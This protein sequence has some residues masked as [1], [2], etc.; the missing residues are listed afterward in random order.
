M[1]ADLMALS[2][3]FFWAAA[4]AFIFKGASKEGGENGAF[5]S[6][7]ITFLLMTVIWVCQHDFSLEQNLNTTGLI[8]FSIAGM[9][10]LFLGRVFFHGSIQYLGSLRGSSVKRMI[11]FFSVVLGVFFL[12]EKLN[13]SDFIGMVTIFLGFGL[14]IYESHR[15]SDSPIDSSNQFIHLK[16]NIRIGLLY[17][18]FS[19]LVYSIGNVFRKTG[20]MN[21]NDPAFGAMIGSLVGAVLFV[22]ASVFLKSYRQSLRNTFSQNNPW[23]IGAGVSASIGQWLYFIAIDESNVSRATLIVSSDIFITLLL[24]YLYFKKQERITHH[25]VGAAFLGFTGTA[26]IILGNKI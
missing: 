22:I 7:L 14:L 24:S 5:L 17:G 18:I 26:V 10:T 4:N 8:H 15:R 2:A 23:L 13:S 19:A 3:A 1:F 9:L 16:K 12:G 21:L 25:T 20:L 11:P 6:I